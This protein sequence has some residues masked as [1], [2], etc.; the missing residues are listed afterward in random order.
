MNRRN[1]IT[2]AFSGLA[3]AGMPSLV[4]L[5]G[6]SAQETLVALLNEMSA[7]YQGLATIFNLPTNSTITQ[8]FQN[9]V[10]AVKAW[11]PGTAAQD[12]VQALQILANNVAPLLTGVINPVFIAAGQFLLNTIVNLI[13]DLDP[14]AV[15]ALAAVMLGRKI[16]GGQ[17]A[18][19]SR[20]KGQWNSL[21]KDEKSTFDAG[22]K[23]LGTRYPQLAA[24]K[25][26]A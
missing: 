20:S 17:F 9:A 13:E 3:L 19:I 16:A 24:V 21:A 25:L 8:A 7:A 26:A 15:P 12:V 22:W 23:A 14:N 4:L 2:R 10:A 11:V 1:F 18:P 6:C 5:T